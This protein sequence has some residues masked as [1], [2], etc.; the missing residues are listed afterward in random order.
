MIYIYIYISIF[1]YLYRFIEIYKRYIDD[2]RDTCKTFLLLNIYL[3][4]LLI[5]L[6]QAYIKRIHNFF[7]LHFL[8]NQIALV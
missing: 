3:Y 1:I 8:Y 6:A 7:F 5:C 2:L 4:R